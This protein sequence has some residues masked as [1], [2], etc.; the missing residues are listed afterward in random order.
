MK[1]L[2]IIFAAFL[3]VF[4][5]S[6]NTKNNTE[7]IITDFIYE[8]KT[9]TGG[10]ISDGKNLK[11]ITIESHKNSENII[12]D[13]HDILDNKTVASTEPPVFGVSYEYY[14]YRFTVKIHGIR[15]HEI[16]FG[17]D[18]SS[19]F[20][21]DLY[22]LPFLDD[23]GIEFA[24]SLNKPVKYKVYELHDPAKIVI[25]IKEADFPKNLPVIYSV[26]TSSE[27]HFETLGHIAEDLAVMGESNVRIMKSENGNLFVEANTKMSLEKAE[28]K[29]AILNSQLKYAEFFVEERFP[30][31]IP[32]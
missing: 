1:F 32:R 6:C 12:I 21:R 9:V 22:M 17:S 5:N 30:E 13:I 16:F 23:S 3:V 11:N 10:V 14:P 15:R 24:I 27:Y 28:K 29:A 19:N 8:P 25:E 18:I 20:V 26:R 31:T 4:C 7:K 2:S